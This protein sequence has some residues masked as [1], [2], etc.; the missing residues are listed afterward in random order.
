ML[1]LFIFV[2]LFYSFHDFSGVITFLTSSQNTVNHWLCSEMNQTE[3][4][5]YQTQYVSCICLM[6]VD[7]NEN[8]LVDMRLAEY[9]LIVQL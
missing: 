9:L 8:N 2:S 7:I 5:C 6:P 3:S 4:E 1:S